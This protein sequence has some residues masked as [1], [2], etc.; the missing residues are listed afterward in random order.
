MPLILIINFFWIS[1]QMI[2]N[3][4]VILTALIVYGHSEIIKD[5][6]ACVFEA[7]DS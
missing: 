5:G 7:G 2:G 6:G 1:N 4:I 3:K